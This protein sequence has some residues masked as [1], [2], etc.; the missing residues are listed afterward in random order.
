MANKSLFAAYRGRRSPGVDTLNRAGGTA[1]RYAASHKLAQ[2]AMTGTF[3]DTFYAQAGDQLADMVSACASVEPAFMAKT[4]V[5]ARQNGHM[6]DAPAFLVAMLSTR[7]GDLFER[8]FAR[9][10]DNG[11]ML[12][13]FVQIM[14]SGVVGRKSLGTRPKRAVQNWLN[15]AS[16]R[17]LIRAA[18]GQSPSLADVIKMV[19]PKPTTREREAFYAW[20]IGKPC[21]V[22]LLPKAVQDFVRFKTT[23]EGEL[24]DIPFQ[25]LTALPLNK[26][27]W[28][29][30]AHQGGWQMVRMNLNTFARKGVFQLDGMDQ[31]IAEKLA[32]P[33]EIA[34]ARTLPY[35][36]MVAARMA[37]ENM[38]EA[39]R[40]ALEAAMEIAVANTPK[41]EGNIVVCPDV[42]GS[43]AMPLTGY[44]PGASSAVRC[45]DVAALVAAA[46]LRTN[47]QTRVMPF[48]TAVRNVRLR[49][50]DSVATNARVLAARHGGGTDC[51]VAL[52]RLNAERARPDLVVFVSDNESWADPRYHNATA[53]LR[54]WDK[55]K[56][57][58]SKARLVCIDIAPYGT[59]QAPDRD[60]VM[61]VGGFSD[62]VFDAVAAFARGERG[63]QHWVS[64]IE[65]TKV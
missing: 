29:Q 60:D 50:Q 25:M 21:D 34:R 57:R 43:M 4:A 63:A 49:S 42:S 15:A 7:E 16:D 14:R 32:D 18:V 17:Q 62:A 51:S 5:Y 33:D 36:V 47:P 41:V 46:F 24:P 54:E 65:K 13:S 30:L 38:P 31:V 20:L 48:D 39:V 3:N 26:E 27:H 53:M 40:E 55:L 56:A 2:I 12:R 9:V 19:H 45:V 52:A 64:Q 11:R 22:A 8:A 1:Y 23:G 59:C 35:Q 28:A 44:R 37:V 10:I 6:K 61:N 58:H